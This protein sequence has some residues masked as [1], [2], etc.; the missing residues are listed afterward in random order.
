[1]V[2]LVAGCGGSNGEPKLPETEAAAAP[3]QRSAMRVAQELGTIDESAVDRAFESFSPQLQSCHR[4]ALTRVRYVGGDVTFFLRLGADGHPRFVHVRETTLGDRE[5]E[6]CLVDALLGA[7][8]PKPNGGDAEISKRVA[9]DPPSTARR[10]VEWTPDKLGPLL[11]QLDAPARQ[12]KS[13]GDG[14]FTVTAYVV[15]KGKSGR[16]LSAGVAPPSAEADA[17]S[18]CLLHLVEST[19][20]PPPGR[21]PAKVSFPL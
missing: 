12:C 8:W 7:T 16:V 9:F 10:P 18:E 13:P 11:R 21:V 3:E 17:R 2:G 4:A 14:V 5:M 1:M 19:H 15:T 6:R 20:L